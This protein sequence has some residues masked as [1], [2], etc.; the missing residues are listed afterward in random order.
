MDKY[1]LSCGHALPPTET[2]CPFCGRPRNLDPENPSAPGNQDVQNDSAQKADGTATST[3]ATPVREFSGPGQAEK[4]QEKADSDSDNSSIL[5]KA[6]LAGFLVIL[7]AMA[8]VFGYL[9]IQSNRL[10]KTYAASSKLVRGCGILELEEKAE[11]LAERWDGTGILMLSERKNIVSELEKLAVSAESLRG[12]FQIQAERLDA[13]RNEAKNY[14][15][16]ISTDKYQDLLNRAAEAI[17]NGDAVQADL[18]LKLCE[19]ALP[20]LRSGM[21]F[22]VCLDAG[23]EGIKIGASEGTAVPSTP[24]DTETES[25][26]AV[27]TDPSL[28]VNLSMRVQQVDVHNYPEVSLFLEIRDEATGVV[29]KDLT[30]PMFMIDKRDA[31]GDYIRQTVSSVRQLDEQEALSVVIAVDVSGSMEGSRIREV[32]QVLRDFLSTLQYSTGDEVSLVSFAS[33]VRLEEGFCG[34]LG[35]LTDSVDYL[36]TGD[37]TSLYD[38]LYASVCSAAVRSGARCVLAFTDGKDDYSNCTAQDVISAATQYNVPIFIIGIGETDASTL[39]LICRASGG[40]Y[41]DT[42][43][44]PSMSQLYEDAYQGEKELYQIRFTDNTGAGATDSTDIRVVCSNSLYEGACTHSY[45]LSALLDVEAANFYNSSPE[46][47]VEMYIKC[48]ADARTY[49][50]INL[51]APYL[52]YNSNFYKNQKKF[53]EN[54][55]AGLRLESFEILSVDYNNSSDCV[56]TTRESY[57]VQGKTTLQLVVQQCKY[58]VGEYA[59][60]WLI[61][62]FAENVK[63]LQIVD[64]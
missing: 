10:S 29:P 35:I 19:Q 37:R 22:H 6:L 27:T 64:Q 38:A 15:D 44:F 41:Y 13:F 3:P 1:C 32:K 46:Y 4:E 59:G 20:A 7:L 63:V 47:D 16:S 9:F 31:N 62:D 17:S 48:F 12:D 28:A 23:K 8:G 18:L 34:D 53:I 49:S 21:D 55:P 61:Y 14:A 11:A 52:L 40:G 58:C 25:E 30:A 57:Y 24:V 5:P 33:D 2:I 43:N 45:E 39:Q 54:S 60:E 26:P 56:V 51:I 36:R 50:D 42:Y